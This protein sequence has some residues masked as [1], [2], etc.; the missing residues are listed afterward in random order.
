MNS[1]VGA[2]ITNIEYM[3]YL[4]H[5]TDLYITLTCSTLNNQIGIICS[6]A[7]SSGHIQR[8]I[9]STSFGLLQADAPTTFGRFSISSNYFF[10]TSYMYFMTL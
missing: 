2:I 7:K 1:S 6:I 5:V 9:A 8:D 3:H 4:P 10:L